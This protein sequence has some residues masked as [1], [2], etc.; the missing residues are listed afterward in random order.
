M[1]HKKIFLHRLFSYN[2]SQNCN[3]YGF[4]PDV[5]HFL[6]KYDL[7]EHLNSYMYLQN[8]TFVNKLEWKKSVNSAVLDH[9]TTS[10]S[11]CMLRNNEFTQ[12]WHITGNNKPDWIW[13]IPTDV[14]VWLQWHMIKATN[15]KLKNAA[16]Y[17]ALI[18]V[19]KNLIYNI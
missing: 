4:I 6:Y 10:G 1:H 15:P 3:H 17:K 18:C 7:L 16:I 2:N 13:K 11:N 9:S 12:F 14:H 5:I 8:G 19:K